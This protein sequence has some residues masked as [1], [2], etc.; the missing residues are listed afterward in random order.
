MIDVPDIRQTT[1]YTCGPA[2]VRA[3]LAVHGWQFSERALEDAMGATPNAGTSPRG[4]LAA[5]RTIG[6]AHT[7]GTMDLADLRHFTRRGVPVVALITGSAGIGHYVTVAGVDRWYVYFHDPAGGTTA[8]YRR[9]RFLDVWRD[10]DWRQW[11]V[12]IRQRPK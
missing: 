5:M 3:A 4:I 10:G 11:G 2:A 6:F 7:A 8:G 12:A 9:R 1:G